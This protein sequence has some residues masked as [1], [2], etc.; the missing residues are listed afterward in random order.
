MGFHLAG[1]GQYV[2][3]NGNWLDLTCMV[4]PITCPTSGSNNIT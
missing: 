4:R 1:G 2:E 3:F